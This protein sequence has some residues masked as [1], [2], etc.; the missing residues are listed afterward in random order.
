[1]NEIA[2]K[3]FAAIGILMAMLRLIELVIKFL[4]WCL[5]KVRE[6]EEEQMNLEQI[7]GIISGLGKGAG[8]MGVPYAE[9]VGDAAMLADKWVKAEAARQGKS[10][11]EIVSAALA[12]AEDNAAELLSDLARLHAESQEDTQPDS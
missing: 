4:G 6:R 1:M 3:V 5:A 7:L 10:E 2:I 9:L 12:G 11:Q 8:A